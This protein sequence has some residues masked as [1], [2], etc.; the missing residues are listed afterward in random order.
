MKKFFPVLVFLALNLASAPTRAAE[1]VV[2]FIQLDDR[3]RIE[4]DGHLFSEYIF[5]GV[6]KPCFY[7]ILDGDGTSYTRDY[8]F[9]RNPIEEID[10]DWHRGVWF[11]HG[12]VNGHDFWRELPEKKTGLIVHD[13]ILE[14]RDGAKGIL[15]AR[16]RWV[17]ANS[18][19]ICTDE[20]TVCV[21]R[22]A[23]G[24]FLDYEVTLHASEGPVILGD[25]EEGS[26]ALRVNESI[27]VTHGKGKSTRPGTGHLVITSGESDLKA[28]GKRSPWSD[29]SGTLPDGRTIGIALFDHPSNPRHPTWWHARPYGLLAANPFGK[30]D[31]EKLADEHAGDIQI[32]A[33]GQ[34]TLRYRLYFHRGDEK[35]AHV[36][37]TYR[38]YTR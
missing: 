16:S 4:I 25:T 33:G 15:R 9:K 28:W 5:L 2:K 11:A 24:T 37:D 8:P 21:Q 13:A 17:A 19:V 3:V 23:A 34:L 30:H 10:H 32:P 14:T 1:D 20:T 36:A 12:L 7:P 31:F 26:M 27:R 22:S 35:T 38:N 29:Y 18:K 6:P